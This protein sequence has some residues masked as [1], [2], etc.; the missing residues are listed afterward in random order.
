[1]RILHV[2]RTLDPADGGPPA[3]ALNLAAAQAKA[4]HKVFVLSQE[5]A[6]RATVIDQYLADIAGADLLILDR[7]VA[8]RIERWSAVTA[9]RRFNAHCP[10]VDLAHLHGVWTPILLRTAKEARRRQLPYVL[11]PHGMLDPFCLSQRRLKKK[12]ALAVAYRR[13]L[14]GARVVHALNADEQ[15]LMK[16]L[17]L[18]APAIV[19]PNGVNLE[20]LHPLPEPGTFRSAHP[21]LEARPFFLFL[22]RLHFKKGLDLLAEG[23]A[24]FINRGGGMDLVVAG[25]DEGVR[26]DFEQRIAAHGLQARVHVVGPIYGGQKLAALRDAAAFVLPSRQEGFSVAITEAL[27]CRLPVAITESCHFPEVAEAGAGLI[28]PLDPE[29]LAE[30]MVKIDEDPG[31]SHAM[32]QAGAR[33]V[34]EHY[35][36]ERVAGRMI[37]AYE[38]LIG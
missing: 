29:A 12:I 2:I 33:L 38:R 23:F 20:D 32:G 21:E 5:A 1:M 14:N 3:V 4:G 10:K 30:A 6:D 35:T 16:P 37:Q 11:A 34:E 7:V 15:R 27:A 17:G 13:M 24:R 28:V 31:A 25:P 19:I 18:T 8:G 22:S 9:L 36:W 26:D